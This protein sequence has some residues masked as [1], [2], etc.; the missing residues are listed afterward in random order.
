MCVSACFVSGCKCKNF[1]PSGD[2]QVVKGVYVQQ[3]VEFNFCIILNLFSMY[4]FV[5]VIF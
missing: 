2:E 3:T 4:Q 5:L 1:R